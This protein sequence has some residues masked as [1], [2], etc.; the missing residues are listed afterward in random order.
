MDKKNFFFATKNSTRLSTDVGML[1]QQ[2]HYYVHTLPYDY[3]MKIK[4]FNA[5]NQANYPTTD[6]NGSHLHT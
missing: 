5:D 2:G 4:S 3:K 6:M 1:L